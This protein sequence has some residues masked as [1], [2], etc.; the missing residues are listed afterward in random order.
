MWQGRWRDA[1]SA[2]VDVAG[3]HAASLRTRGY[4]ALGELARALPEAAAATKAADREG[5]E[6]AQLLAA[7][8]RLRVD[9]AA[10]DAPHRAF[11]MR[12]LEQLTLGCQALELERVAHAR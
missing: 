7:V 11:T 1:L 6:A 10:A 12:S 2:L 9:V 4:L 8:T 3:C 5:N